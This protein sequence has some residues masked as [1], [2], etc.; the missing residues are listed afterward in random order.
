MLY[1]NEIKWIHWDSRIHNRLIG[2]GFPYSVI[3]ILVEHIAS[4]QNQIKEAKRIYETYYKNIPNALLEH[5]GTARGIETLGYKTYMESL[6][7]K[8]D[9]AIVSLNKFRTVSSQIP[10]LCGQ[11]NCIL[12]YIIHGARWINIEIRTNTIAQ[13]MD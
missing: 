8:L 6:Q 1:E 5:F 10:N 3:R 2:R 4:I 9:V 11:V 13:R 12:D 7:S